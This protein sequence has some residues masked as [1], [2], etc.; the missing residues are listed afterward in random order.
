MGIVSRWDALQRLQKSYRVWIAQRLSRVRTVLIEEN[1]CIL[2]LKLNDTSEM[3]FAILYRVE[4]LS[5][6]SKFPSAWE[7]FF[8]NGFQNYRMTST[9]GTKWMWAYGEDLF[10][11]I[12]IENVKWVQH[13]TLIKSAL[14]Q[15]VAKGDKRPLK[16][17]QEKST[18]KVYLITF[19]TEVQGVH[20]KSVISRKIARLGGSH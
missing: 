13:F 20:L 6:S 4:Q 8:Q 3:W 11:E 10:D 1:G 18:G 9:N 2:L 17:K 16:A 15:W 19:T 7:K 12:V 14:K 5:K